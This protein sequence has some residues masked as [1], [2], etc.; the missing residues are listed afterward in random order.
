MKAG[1]RATAL[2]AAFIAAATSVARPAA[3]QSVTLGVPLVAGD[4][5]SPA[6]PITVTALPGPPQFGPYSVSIELSFEPQ[7]RT[8]FFVDAAT[9][10]SAT[11]QVDKLMTQRTIV[12]FRARL[13]DNFGVVVATALAQHPV[14]SWL[15]LVS[16]IGGTPTIVNTRTPRFTWSSPPLTLPPG[17]WVYD[18]SVVNTANGQTILRGGLSDTSFVFTDSLESNTS[19][20]WQ[21]HARAQNGPPSDQITIVS[22]STFVVASPEQPTFTLFY[23]NFPNPFGRGTRSSFTC[24]WFDLARASTVTL[25]IYDIRLHE[26]RHIVPGPIGGGTLPLGS[27][28]RENLGQQTG[29]DQ[30]LAWDGRDDAG[31]MVPQGLY[32]AV[33]EGA[34]VRT[35]KKVL[36]RGP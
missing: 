29:C 4:S 15:K 23:Q 26:V 36:Y 2:M 27:Y 1:R 6:P 31:R 3:A 32:L 35:S 17:L 33:F 13:T 14:Q 30:R 20:R 10:L 21:V 12:Y 24:F 5:V 25:T 34:G 16:P 19:Y 18:L 9:S 11:F 28:G 7:F 22:S 8:P